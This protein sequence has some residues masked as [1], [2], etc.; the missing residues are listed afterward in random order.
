M[1]FPKEAKPRSQS[2]IEAEESLKQ[3]RETARQR[4]RT[5]EQRQRQTTNQQSLMSSPLQRRSIPNLSPLQ[6]RH[7]DNLSFQLLGHE[8]YL[9]H[10]AKTVV[11]PSTFV[12][13]PPQHSSSHAAVNTTDTATNFS[14]KRG[15]G[16]KPRR[17]HEMMQLSLTRSRGS[18]VQPKKQP[19]TAELLQHADASLDRAQSLHMSE[20]LKETKRTP[21]ELLSS[22]A[23][24]M[25]EEFRQA[26][27]TCLQHLSQ[28]DDVASFDVATLLTRCWKDHVEV[29]YDMTV[30]QQQSK[31]AAATAA[32]DQKGSNTQEKTTTATSTTRSSTGAT[33][34]ITTTTTTTTTTTMTANTNNDH[35]DETETECLHATF[36]IGSSPRRSDRTKNKNKTLIVAEQQEREIENVTDSND[37]STAAVTMATTV[38]DSIGS[39]PTNFL[40]KQM[41]SSLEEMHLHLSSVR[42]LRSVM[43]DEQT[44]FLQSND[45][46]WNMKKETYLSS[47]YDIPDLPSERGNFSGHWYRCVLTICCLV[48]FYQ[49]SVLFSFSS[50]FTILICFGQASR[51]WWRQSHRRENY[52]YQPKYNMGLVSIS[53]QHGKKAHV[54]QCNP[55][56][57]HCSQKISKQIYQHS[58]NEI[59][60]EFNKI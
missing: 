20:M 34:T 24:D 32:T 8:A 26:F 60:Q 42:R 52:G 27:T 44:R 57:N 29:L 4:Q 55:N 31:S 13:N 43:F 46:E 58:T 14:F 45:M 1:K 22:T 53:T 51:H 10:V 9:Q 15:A 11:P 47:S 19:S 30:D 37:S 41:L 59:D 23:I 40:Q 28:R 21:A 54:S 7:V 3:Q 35:K 5:I 18:T 25:H 50:N 39:P 49:V 12:L 17:A 33:T 56:T 2:A 38:G 48:F 36:P 16:W 6:D